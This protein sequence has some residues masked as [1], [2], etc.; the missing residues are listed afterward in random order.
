MFAPNAE[1]PGVFVAEPFS[2]AAFV[3]DRSPQKILVTDFRFPSWLPQLS[4]FPNNP[5]NF[6]NTELS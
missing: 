6:E 1:A 5:M 3:D 4:D 2:I